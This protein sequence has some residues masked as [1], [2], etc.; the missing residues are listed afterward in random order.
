VVKLKRKVLTPERERR[1]LRHK[2]AITAANNAVRREKVKRKNR[3]KN[4]VARKSR[5][6]NR[7]HKR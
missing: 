4:R 3:A 1:R 6:I 5:Q 2:R 7:R